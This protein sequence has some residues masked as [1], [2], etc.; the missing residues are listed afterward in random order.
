MKVLR[1]GPAPLPLGAMDT[2]PQA[3][4]R[5]RGEPFF[6]ATRG[7]GV[8]GELVEGDL[9]FARPVTVAIPGGPEGDVIE[10]VGAVE[11][12]RLAEPPHELPGLIF[13]DA[14]RGTERGEFLRSL[15][16]PGTV[17]TLTGPGVV[18]PSDPRFRRKR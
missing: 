13:L 11:S 10:Q 5:V 4:L 12:A 6:I 17:L 14:M 2:Q 16:Q 7:L 3:K 18:E 1:A 9:F 8:I 15:L